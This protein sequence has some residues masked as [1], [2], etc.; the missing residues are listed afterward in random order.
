M[1]SRRRGA[2]CRAHPRAVTQRPASGTS[3]VS[4]PL[5]PFPGPNVS[6]TTTGETQ[7]PGLAGLS[8]QVQRCTHPNITP[9]RSRHAAGG[10]G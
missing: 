7:A 6:L 9:K 2:G 10:K 1:P 5:L 4:S 8:L 3:S